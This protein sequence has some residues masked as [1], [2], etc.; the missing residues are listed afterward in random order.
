MKE[1]LGKMR[2]MLSLEGVFTSDEDLKAEQVR[3]LAE[4]GA[5]FSEEELARLSVLDIADLADHFE[6]IKKG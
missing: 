6:E 4:T 3:R 5:E 1:V 2:D